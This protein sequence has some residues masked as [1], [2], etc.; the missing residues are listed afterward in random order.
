MQLTADEILA[1]QLGTQQ[2]WTKALALVTKAKKYFP[3]AYRTTPP[4]VYNSTAAG[5]ASCAGWMRR[6]C[7]VPGNE[8]TQTFPPAQGP[9]PAAEMAIAAFLVA[10]GPHS[11]LSA[12][13]ATINRGDWSD[14]IFRLHRLDT[15]KPTGA[16]TETKPGVFSRPVNAP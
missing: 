8:S 16:C 6:Q 12:P 9:L 14:P 3:Q 5:A 4:F 15:G 13:A 10:R 7:A 2:A 1:L 11:Y